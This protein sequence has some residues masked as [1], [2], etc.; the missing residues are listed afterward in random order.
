LLRWQHPERGLV[1]PADFIDVLEET[2]LIV[3]VG[4]WAIRTVCREILA[5]QA[6]G[7]TA[8]PV[9]VNLSVRQFAQK[10]LDVMVGEILRET[11]VDPQLLELELT[12]SLLMSE[13]EEAAQMLRNLKSFGV[14]LAV[15]DFGTGYSSLAYLKRFPI[16][17][18]KIDRAFVRDCITDPGDAMIACAVINL[19][20]SL[21]LKAVAEGVETEAQLN[22]LRSHGC[23]Q[24]QG[25]FLARPLHIEHATK[26]IADGVRLQPSVTDIGSDATTLLL[27]DDS[28]DDLELNR[29]HFEPDGYRIL[30]ANGSQ[31]AFAF[32]ARERVHAVISDQ[33]MPGMSGADFLAAVRKLYPDVTRIMLS[34]SDDPALLPK[35]VNDAGIHKFLSK[36]WNPE[37][38][39]LALREV[40][41]PRP[42]AR[43]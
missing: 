32:L 16:D 6:Q 24:I 29:I 13:P 1:L 14:R 42:E 28:S 38:L 31:T 43:H 20:H 34:G 37:R 19:A 35:A 17:A 41:P 33:N 30:T 10:N 8:L 36:D 26:A 22:F 27:V 11:G 40:F 23:D 15:D 21:N 7:L 9:A 12:E 4:E 39:R 25:Y 3:Q 18:L 5:W 2:G